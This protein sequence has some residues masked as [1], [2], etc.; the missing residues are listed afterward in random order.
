MPAEVGSGSFWSGM[1]EYVQSGPDALQKV[2]DD[3]EA[4]WPQ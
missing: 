4:S 3:I 1:V 2:L